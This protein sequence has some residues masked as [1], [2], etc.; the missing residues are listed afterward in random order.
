MLRSII[1][2]VVEEYH[3]AAALDLLIREQKGEDISGL[4]ETFLLNPYTGMPFA[5]DAATR[6]LIAGYGTKHTELDEFKL[7]W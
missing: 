5:Y 7:P 1:G 3:Q 4:T 6:T 2:I